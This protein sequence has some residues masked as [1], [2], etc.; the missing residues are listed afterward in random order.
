M[1]R[2]LR[3]RAGRNTI[4]WLLIA[5]VAFGFTARARATEGTDRDD[6]RDLQEQVLK[7]K[8]SEARGRQRMQEDEKLIR[9]LEERLDRFDARRQVLEQASHRQ[10]ATNRQLENSTIEQIQKL[11]EQ[12]SS[13]AAPPQFDSWIN[14]YL[15]Q[16]QFT[17]AGAAAGDFIYDRQTNQNTFSLVF[18]PLFLYRLNDWMLFEA[19]FEAA[20]PL[21]SS[22]EFGLPVANAQIFLNEYMELVAGVFDQPFGDFYEAQSALWVNRMVTAPL[23]YGAEALIPPSDLGL[24]LRGSTQWG[25]LGQDIDYTLWVGNGPTYDTSVA[26]PVVGQTLESPTN[27]GAQSHGRAYGARFRVYPLPLDANLGR[28]ELGASTYNGKW[29]SGK[30]LN[31]WGVDFNYLRGSLQARGEFLEA[32]RQMPSAHADNRQGW[33]MQVG[34]FLRDLPTLHV[35]GQVQ[36]VL[37]RLEPLIR[38]SGVNQ[39]AVITNEIQNTPETAFNGS[40]SIFSPHAREVALGLDYW[41]E[42]SIVWQTE[43]DFELPRAGGTAITLNGGSASAAPAGSTANDRAILT[44]LAIGF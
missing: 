43:F 1:S 14:R 5:T 3:T 18:E 12:V 37:R 20:L 38:Y 32:Y 36:D 26:T 10:E 31:G 21:G 22:A 13:Q 29:Q 33:Y 28:L 27:I 15:G 19:E 11:Q 4:R 25:A 2:N 39:R 8:A 44:Q 40:P 34:Y 7:L 24:Q 9:D 35:G 41:I 42:P 30:W 16:H 17:L 6:Y 23:P